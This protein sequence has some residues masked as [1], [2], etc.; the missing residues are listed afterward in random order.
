MGNC[1][2]DDCMKEIAH[3]YDAYNVPTPNAFQKKPQKPKTD[4][5]LHINPTPN[6]EINENPNDFDYVK[7]GIHA[8]FPSDDDN[9]NNQP[10]NEGET[11]I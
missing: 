2:S 8:D 6:P 3:L 11:N 9:E 5:E 7:S 4:E 10:N 1:C